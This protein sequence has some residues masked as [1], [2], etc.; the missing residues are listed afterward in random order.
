MG[1][2]KKPKILKASPLTEVKVLERPP[3]MN[4]SQEISLML[5]RYYR[6]I[7]ATNFT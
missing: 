7:Y 4:I 2:V 5:R 3:Y 6:D 1:R